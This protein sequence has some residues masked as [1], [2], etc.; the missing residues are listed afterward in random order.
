[1]SALPPPS[2]RDRVDVPLPVEEERV[3]LTRSWLVVAPWVV[4]FVALVVVGVLVLT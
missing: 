3:E 4:A 2:D 1:M